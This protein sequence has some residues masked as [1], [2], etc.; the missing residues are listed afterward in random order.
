MSS[1]LNAITIKT[2]ADGDW[3]N[4]A[5]W[6]NNQVPVNPDSIIIYHYVTINQTLA[7][8]NPTILYIDTLGTICGDYL[9]ETFC[10]ASFVNYGHLFL[11]S[12]KTRAG[13][14]YYEIKCK[15]FI[16][17]SGCP[18]SGSGY[19][20]SIPPN[21]NVTV[22]PPVLCKTQHTNWEGGTQIGIIE[23]ENNTL[24]VYPN[25]ITNEPLTIITLSKTKMKLMDITGN[26]IAG[27][28]FEN[29]T[30]LNFNSLPCGVY[31]LELEIDGKKQIKKILKSN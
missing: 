14:N 9:L 8:N 7:L 16:N 11:N 31:F 17:L 29:K 1:I 21:G 20:N 22:W 2:I 4:A 19:F 25:P 23:L 10:G 30:E 3:E 6:S 28:V 12:I 26:E 24:K 27:H 13:L 15:N 5:I 18:P